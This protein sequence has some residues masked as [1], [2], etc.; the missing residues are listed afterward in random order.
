MSRSHPFANHAEISIELAI[1]EGAQLN[2]DRLLSL[3]HTTR[4]SKEGQ[5]SVPCRMGITRRKILISDL[6]P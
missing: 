2:P 4:E 5:K 6:H 1:I 3:G